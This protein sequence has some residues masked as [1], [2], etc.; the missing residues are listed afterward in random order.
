MSGSCRHCCRHTVCGKNED[1]ELHANENSA[2]FL[3]CQS[4]A[5]VTEEGD[6]A[7]LRYDSVLKQKMPGSLPLGCIGR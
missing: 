6:A 2:C 4:E 3:G 1:T 5:W 7:H